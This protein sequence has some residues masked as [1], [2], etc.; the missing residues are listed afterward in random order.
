MADAVVASAARQEALHEVGAVDSAVVEVDSAV[1]E[2]AEAVEAYRA[3]VAAAADEEAV[4]VVLV[5]ADAV[6]HRVEARKAAA[7]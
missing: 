6:V 1:V 2:A 5:V 3:D 4:G 7:K